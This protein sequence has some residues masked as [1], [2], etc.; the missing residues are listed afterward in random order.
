MAIEF[1]HLEVHH[2]VQP[3]VHLILHYQMVVLILLLLEYRGMLE[4][5]FHKMQILKR[6]IYFRNGKASI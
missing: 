1:V 6:D 2:K 5:L 4:N 3:P